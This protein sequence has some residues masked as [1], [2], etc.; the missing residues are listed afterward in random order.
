[1][2]GACGRDEHTA[3]LAEL[4]WTQAP[5]ATTGVPIEVYV[6][7]TETNR[8]KIRETSNCRRVVVASMCKAR[9]GQCDSGICDVIDRD[10]DGDISL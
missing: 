3:E 7:A 2:R 9:G 10:I 1:M 6:D 4:D 5:D 8:E